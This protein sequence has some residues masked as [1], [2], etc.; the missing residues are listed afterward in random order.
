MK[1]GPLDLGSKVGP[2]PAVRGGV[3]FGALGGFRGGVARKEGHTSSPSETVPREGWTDRVH[4]T[5]KH[6][7]CL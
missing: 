5:H 3:T 4:P 2:S 6:T 7:H 1:D